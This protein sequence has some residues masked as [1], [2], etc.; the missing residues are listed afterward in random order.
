VA[1]DPH[2]VGTN[3]RSGT[4]SHS[5]GGDG[6]EDHYDTIEQLVLGFTVSLSEGDEQH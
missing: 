1:R 2:P 3:P 5:S 4:A 6:N